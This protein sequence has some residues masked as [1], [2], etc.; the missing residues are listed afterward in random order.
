MRRYKH[1]FGPVLSRR[2]GLSLGIDLIN[3]KTCTL[4]C[5]YCECGRTTILTDK[6]DEY[7]NT[8]E[9]IAELTDFL[10]NSPQLDYLTF[11]GSG[12]PTLHSRIGEIINFI[13]TAYPHYKIA[14]L[15]NG[16]LFNDDKLIEEV[17][18]VDL[19]IPSLDAA[20]QEV[21]EKINRPTSGMRIEDIISGL[22][23]L[24][25]N[26]SGLIYLEIFIAPGFN[27]S[28]SEIFHIAEA[29]KRIRPDKI[30]LNSLDRPPAVKGIKKAEYK[31]LL[32]I[33]SFFEPV[34]EIIS[35]YDQRKST[36]DYVDI[37]NLILEMISR[38]PCTRDEIR[39][40]FD[41]R[42][43]EV[44]SILDRLLEDKK[45]EIINGPRGDYFRINK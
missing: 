26:Y 32:K 30:Q 11:S 6:R 3:Y 39:I 42:M 12:E 2:L 14:L 17:K 38:R 18:K 27:D 5:V 37:E 15:T 13:K 35:K 28:E 45:I 43:K 4:N 31:D 41:L 34:A 1:I 16:T 7:I 8:D 19:I 21:F 29:A 10:K 40:L 33:A 44:D 24:R 22:I 36:L 20:T 25:E 23:K 9:V